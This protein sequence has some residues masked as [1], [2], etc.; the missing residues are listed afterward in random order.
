MKISSRLL[1]REG[2]RDDA[3]SSSSHD[4]GPREESVNTE[5]EMDRVRQLVSKEAFHVRQTRMLVFLT[6]LS[7][8]CLVCVLV[9]VVLLIQNEENIKDA[10]RTT[11]NIGTRGWLR[12]IVAH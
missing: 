12:E 7:T 6:L 11:M 8:G 4:D 5:H 10:V 9:Y 3:S 2:T 1:S